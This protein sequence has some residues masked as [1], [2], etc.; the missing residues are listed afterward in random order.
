MGFLFKHRHQAEKANERERLYAAY[1]K[2]LFPVLYCYV[3]FLTLLSI[4]EVKGFFSLKIREELWID[5]DVTT[6]FESEAE[7]I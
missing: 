6:P 7:N 1:W 3:F 5:G 4:S 2:K